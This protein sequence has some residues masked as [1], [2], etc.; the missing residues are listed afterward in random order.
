MSEADRDIVLEILGRALDHQGIGGLGIWLLV[1]RGREAM[2]PA[3]LLAAGEYG[4]ARML[5]VVVPP[6]QLSPRRPPAEPEP[7]R[8]E[9]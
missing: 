5:A 1:P 2:T 7:P 9:S 3:A 6:W 4:R 8:E